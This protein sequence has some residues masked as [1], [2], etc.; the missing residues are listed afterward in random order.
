MAFT[1]IRALMTKLSDNFTFTGSVTGTTVADNSVTN[2][3]FASTIAASNF[4][5]TLPALDGS[6]LTGVGAAVVIA[7]DPLINTNPSGGLGS[8]FVN[9][10][11][12]ETYVCTDATT[13]ANVW[14]NVGTGTGNIA[15]TFFPGELNGYVAG[16]VSPATNAIERVSFSSDGNGVAVTGVLLVAGGER[17]GCSLPNHAYWANGHPG[18]DHIER[19][20]FATE[21]NTTD[22]GNLSSTARRNASSSSSQ[23]HCYWTGGDGG[24]NIIERSADASSADAIDVGDLS[25]SFFNAGNASDQDGGYGYVAGGYYGTTKHIDRFQM[26]ASASGAD[27]G[28]LVQ[29]ASHCGAG[30]STTHGYTFAGGYTASGGQDWIQKYTFSASISSSDIGNLSEGFYGSCG[31][32][33][34][35]NSYNCGGDTYT[36][37]QPSDK[38]DKISHTVDG[39]ATTGIGT[40]TNVKGYLGGNGAHY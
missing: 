5:G 24:I 40:L 15:P 12:G 36:G 39:N 26:A 21:A 37:G 31:V 27:V 14:T 17:T 1:K 6:A 7:S 38:M 18:G 8:V 25:A 2:A 35:T 30:S 13:D 16:G 22:V 11:S 19:M 9:S 20:A 3:K 23:T 4:S 33:S 34:L 29:T 10:T 32:S 28:D